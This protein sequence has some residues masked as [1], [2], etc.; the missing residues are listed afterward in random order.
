[1]VDVIIIEVISDVEIA[2]RELT[3]SLYGVH[4]K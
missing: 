4:T 2:N 3:L 1:M